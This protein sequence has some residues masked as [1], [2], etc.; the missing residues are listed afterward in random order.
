M[1]DA[2]LTFSK[3][4]A[5][6]Q[7]ITQEFEVGELDLEKSL[8]KFKRS[9]VLVKFLKAELKKIESQIEEINLGVQEP[10]QPTPKSPPSNDPSDIPF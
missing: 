2:K 5:E 10:S 8:P 4:Y 3:A 6:L 7:Q 1:S 9:A